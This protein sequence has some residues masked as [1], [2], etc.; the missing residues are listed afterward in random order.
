MRREGEGGEEGFLP[1][2]KLNSEG[3]LLGSQ[4]KQK[5]W[6]RVIQEKGGGRLRKRESEGIRGRLLRDLRVQQ[7]KTG[8][9]EIFRTICKQ[10]KR[11]VKSKGWEKN[12]ETRTPVAKK[13]LRQFFGGK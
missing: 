12:Q 4:K 1:R 2:G 8:N 6:D 9:I 10:Q 5:P 3:E 13:S 11:S 7:K